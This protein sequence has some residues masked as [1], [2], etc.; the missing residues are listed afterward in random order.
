MLRSLAELSS[1]NADDLKWQSTLVLGTAW[2]VLAGIIIGM[3]ISLTIGLLYSSA[4]MGVMLVVALCGFLGGLFGHGLASLLADDVTFAEWVAPSYREEPPQQN[5]ISDHIYLKMER[6][7]KL[8]QPNKN[9]LSGNL[10]Q[11]SIQS[12]KAALL[13][14][15]YGNTQIFE[16]IVAHAHKNIMGNRP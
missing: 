4:V 12:Q 6:E 10:L 11:T 8:F 16:L 7:K 2:G 9:L 5:A 14:P 1:G 13:Q 3:G 15:Y